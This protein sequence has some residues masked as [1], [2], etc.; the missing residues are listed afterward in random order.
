M[1]NAI[2]LKDVVKEYM[3]GDNVIRALDGVNMEI[4]R[5]IMATVIGPSGS[6]KTTLLNIIGALDKPTSGEVYIDGM[7]IVGMDEREL[8][9]YRREKV[10]FVFQEFNLI[11]NLSA[12]ENV[13]LPMEFAGV[14]KRERE[15]RARKLL[16][17]V[18][19]SH[20]SNH[21]PGKLSGGE[22][23]RVAIAR[24][25]ANDPTIILADEPTGNLD[26]R[27]GKEIVMLLKRF[28][29]KE[30]KTVVVV[31]HDSAIQELADLTI[32]IKDGKISKG[33]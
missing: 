7:D 6:G 20:R 32:H 3:L 11:P 31:T 22:Q 8:T 24:A 15:A 30:G 29:E 1:S 13:A 25:L 9:A 23:Q 14:P 28:S 16:E 10:G 17:E 33:E 4:A 2:F 5:G 26:S 27:T 12:L 21:R 19:M 18:K